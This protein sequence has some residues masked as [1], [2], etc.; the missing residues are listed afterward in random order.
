MTKGEEL[1]LAGW[2][3]QFS[4]AGER[5]QLAVESY[6]EMGHE[7]MLLDPVDDLPVAVGKAGCHGCNA[8]EISGLKVI[9]TRK[10]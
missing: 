1:I 4:A 2:R 9:F 6:E 10:V 5:L 8:G 3:R 7:V